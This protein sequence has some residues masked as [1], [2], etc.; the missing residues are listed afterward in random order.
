MTNINLHSIFYHLV[1]DDKFLSKVIETESGEQ[2]KKKSKGKKS[3]MMA[4]MVTDYVQLAPYEEQKYA[5]FPHKFKYFMMPTFVRYGIKNTMDKNLNL[6]NISFLNSINILL[7]PDLYKMSIDDHVR[8]LGLLE[9][10]VRHKISRNF[11]IDK[12]KNTKKVQTANKEIM[13]RLSEG[14]ITPELI[15]AVVNIFEINLLIF[16]FIKN[17]IYLYWAHGYKYPFF[18]PFKK[19][20]FMAYIHGS[21]E[22]IMPLDNELDD[23]DKQ[24]IYIRILTNMSEIKCNEQ[25]KIAIHTMLY[26]DTW[27][28]S[29]NTY[30]KI[31]ETFF[32]KKK[33]NLKLIEKASE[34]FS[35]ESS[36]KSN[37]KSSQKSNEKSSQKSNEKSSQKSNEKSSQKSNEK[38]SQKF[39]ASLKKSIEKSSDE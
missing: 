11:Q 23:E 26:I 32:K 31:I 3:N 8:N 4:D 25:L 24:K 10:F 34:K 18:N 27:K 22:P 16:D 2:K 36:V 21:Y 6:I 39:N 20:F 37:E 35:D 19:I 28:I 13:N 17:E 38:S 12:I 14:K 5:S 33:V 30:I 15:Q 7:R 1:G 29:T 9:D